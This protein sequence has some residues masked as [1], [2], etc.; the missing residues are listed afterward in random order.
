ML[1]QRK[2]EGLRKTRN[3]R[4]WAVVITAILLPIALIAIILTAPISEMHIAVWNVDE[5]DTAYIRLYLD[6]T[7]AA[8]L[9]AGPGGAAGWVFHVP[10]GTHSVGVDFMYNH[11]PGSPHD[12]V[13]DYLW[14]ARV[15]FNGI[16][17]RH[18][19]IDSEGINTHHPYNFIDV[20]YINKPPLMQAIDDPHFMPP[21]I[22]LSALHVLFAAAIWNYQRTPTIE[23]S[24]EKRP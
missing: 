23:E 10:P 12:E 13:I 4:F 21:V 5:A 15:E 8:D 11:T 24:P 14:I 19:C 3:W 2:Q 22:T 6:G 7:R 17:H 20:F 18:L 1:P 9:Y 16:L